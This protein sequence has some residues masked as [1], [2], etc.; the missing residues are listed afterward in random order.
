MMSNN[1]AF[2]F[3]ALATAAFVAVVAFGIATGGASA[4]A[5]DADNSRGALTSVIEGFAR[6]TIPLD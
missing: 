6:E 5:T 4:G 2:I 1:P 3:S